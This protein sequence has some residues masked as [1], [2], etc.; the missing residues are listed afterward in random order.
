MGRS[1]SVTHH[2]DVI[3]SCAT[4]ITL[5]K[6]AMCCNSMVA[7]RA[8]DCTCPAAEP[9]ISSPAAGDRSVPAAPASDRCSPSCSCRSGLRSAL[10]I[11]WKLLARP[12]RPCVCT[13][14][15]QSDAFVVDPALRYVSRRAHDF[16]V[17]KI[18]CC[19]FVWVEWRAIEHV[20]AH[21]AVSRCPRDGCFPAATTRGTAPPARRDCCRRGA[22]P[23]CGTAAAELSVCPTS[24]R[25]PASAP[26]GSPS[27]G[28]H[29]TVDHC[30]AAS[31]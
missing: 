25:C 27:P 21:V 18:Q 8:H 11:G 3:I 12:A 16:V 4:W 24:A 26:A 9:L 5:Q 17:A 30:L 20:P 2:C 29:V 22:P 31:G 13:A 28:V 19:R 10:V 23:D 14:H 6:P 1:P 7:A 15:V